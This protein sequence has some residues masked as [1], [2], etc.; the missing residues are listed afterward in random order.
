[1]RSIMKQQWTKMSVK[2]LK[3]GASHGPPTEFRESRR[4]SKNE[5]LNAS[6]ASALYSEVHIMWYD[7]WMG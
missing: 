5:R 7:S 3:G 1:V 2:N 4:H 6:G